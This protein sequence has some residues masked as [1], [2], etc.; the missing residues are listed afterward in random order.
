MHPRD[1]HQFGRTVQTASAFFATDPEQLTARDEALF[2]GRL[3]TGNATFKR[4]APGR[5]RMIDEALVAQLDRAGAGIDRVLDLGIS[6]GV[7]TVE[8][9]EALGRS[10][11]SVS[12]TG[13]DRA[14]EAFLVDLPLGCRAL[15][16]PNGH[17]LQYEVLGRAIRPWTR[18]LDYLTGMALARRLVN[19]MLGPRARARAAQ[20]A[21][22]ASVALVSPRLSRSVGVELVEDDVTR[23]NPHFV[24]GFDLV[25]AANILNRH[26]FDADALERAVGN[27]K[28]YLRGPGAWLLVVRTHGDSDHQGTLFRMNEAH[29][30]DVIERWGEGSEVEALV[31]QPRQDL[32]QR[33]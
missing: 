12:V 33:G 26:Y 17:V 20:R 11:R 1:S 31:S 19:H 16:E 18:R 10:G 6:S 9:A 29:G 24:G 28:S 3:K 7:T 5:L 27:V 8:L 23:S 21:I 22:A 14:L 25:R 2:F 4:T 32:N 30:L 13:T 15:V